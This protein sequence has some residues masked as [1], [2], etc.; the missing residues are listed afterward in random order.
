M[1][2][3]WLKS[4]AIFCI[5]LG[6][7]FIILMV[8]LAMIENHPKVHKEPKCQFNNGTDG[9]CVRKSRCT[10]QVD[11]E[12]I[13]IGMDCKTHKSTVCCSV[14]SLVNDKFESFEDHKNFKVFKHNGCGQNIHSIFNDEEQLEFPW[15]VSLGHQILGS[16]KKFT[17]GGSFITKN[18]IL[19]SARCA[20]EL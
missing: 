5:P 7:L 15:I 17:C 18:F 1:S 20:T 3:K 16:H 2:L 12:S 9:I 13:F 14:G 19:T 11:F 4:S 8:V 6:I 10:E